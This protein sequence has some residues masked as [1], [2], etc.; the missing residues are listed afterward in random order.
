MAPPIQLYNPAF[1]RFINDAT[2]PALEIPDNVVLATADLMCKASAIYEDENTRKIRIRP[3]LK[4]AISYGITQMISDDRTTPDGVIVWT[5]SGTDGSL[6]EV[7]ALL[8]EEEKRELGEG[9]CDAS[10]QASFSMLKY[11]VQS[12]VRQFLLPWVISLTSCARMTPFEGDVVALH[13]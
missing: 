3:A 4:N 8:I 1:A 6:N 10:T 12:N 5:M 11:W 9:G 13:S 7:V 2:N